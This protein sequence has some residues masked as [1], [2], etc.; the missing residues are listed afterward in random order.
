MT[1]AGLTIQPILCILELLAIGF[2]SELYFS[3]YEREQRVILAEAYIAAG[4]PGGAALARK[5]I[6]GN[7]DFA[8]GFLQTKT[9]AR[10]I[11]AVT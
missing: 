3:V 2:G 7:D 4:V 9:P 10:G 1:L 8:A 5:D 6:A 11:A